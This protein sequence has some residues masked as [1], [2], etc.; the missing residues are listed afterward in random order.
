MN[1]IGI[2]GKEDEKEGGGDNSHENSRNKFGN[3]PRQK[4]PRIKTSLN[5][6]CD[7]HDN[8]RKNLLKRGWG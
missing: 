4:V 2:R 3:N 8:P 6:Q 7:Y 5:N 1:G